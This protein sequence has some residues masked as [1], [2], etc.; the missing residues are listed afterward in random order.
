[1]DNKFRNN[2]ILVVIG[3]VL[4][5]LLMNFS[6][7]LGFFGI[8]GKILLPIM[9]GLILAFVLNVPMS[10]FER[11]FGRIFM[12]AKKPPKPAVISL[13]S[14]ILTLLCIILVVALAITLAL[15]EIVESVKR[16]YEQIKAQIP[17]LIETLNG[18][19]IDTSRL[20]ELMKN[21]NFEGFVSKI[22]VGAGSVLSSFWSVASSTVS[23]VSTTFFAIV[24]SIY[25]LLDKRNLSRQMKKLLYANLKQNV[26]DKI[27]EVCRL[28]NETYSKFLSGQC[29]EA[30]ILGFLIFL[31]FSVFRLPYAALI[32]FLTS[33][34]AFIPYVGAFASCAIGA[35]LILL[36]SP[37]K[38]ITC[39]IVYLVVQFV[40]NQFIYPHVVGSSVGLSAMW[41][42]LA[43]I[44]G[45]KLFGVVGI[46]FFIPLTAV[47]YTLVQ[48]YVNGK[49]K[50]KRLNIE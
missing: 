34:F 17:L 6:A 21:M 37:S 1:M 45:G 49:L 20:T 16:I 5:A 9:V 48:R 28:S 23:G 50:L 11:L 7:V 38:V 42:L 44:V 25:T 29:I 36:D 19:N 13:M 39:I 27:I 3:V 35:F 26:V 40:E 8:V 14:L 15:P 31:A 32:A 2:I 4:L 12:K 43:A 46:I 18:Y 47:V 41:T 22:S 33:F 30:C 24:I 10:A